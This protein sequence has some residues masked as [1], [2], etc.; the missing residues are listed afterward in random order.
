MTL[1]ALIVGATRQL[2]C[3]SSDFLCDAKHDDDDN[4]KTDGAPKTQ[5][6]PKVQSESIHT[7]NDRYMM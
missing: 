1:T 6:Q 7:S 5:L 4:T 2:R 3:S